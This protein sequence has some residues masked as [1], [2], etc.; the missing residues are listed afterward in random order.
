M[1]DR[2][3][4]MRFMAERVLR[5]FIQKCYARAPAR[6]SSRPRN[7][8]LA[9]TQLCMCLVINASSLYSLKWIMVLYHHLHQA[10]VI[11]ILLRSH[12]YHVIEFITLILE[13]CRSNFATVVTQ[14]H[15]EQLAFPSGIAPCPNCRFVHDTCLYHPPGFI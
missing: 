9:L 12:L 3:K 4:C 6:R 5:G 11:Q 2:L 1:R 15:T 13:S 10:L 14:V 8:V 7:V